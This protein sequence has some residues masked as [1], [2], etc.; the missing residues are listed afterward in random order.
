MRIRAAVAA[1]RADMDGE[2]A[3]NPTVRFCFALVRLM[4]LAA[5]DAAGIEAMNARTA[6]RA[7]RTG[8]DGHTWSMHRP[9]FAVA[10]EMAAA[11]EEGQAG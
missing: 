2:D 9:E 10:L 4:E 3:S 11:Y 6:E 8:G 5:D 1:M 7:A